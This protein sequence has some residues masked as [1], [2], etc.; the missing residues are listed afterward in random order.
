MLHTTAVLDA[1]LLMTRYLR[2]LLLS[3]AE[4]RLY[5]PRW[6]PDLM[7]EMQRAVQRRAGE[8]WDSVRAQRIARTIELVNRAFPDACVEGYADLIET[9]QLPDPDDRHVLAAALTGNAD[10]IVTFNLKDFPAAALA[11]HGV[12]AI[13]PDAFISRLVDAAPSEVLAAIK[14]MTMRWQR[15]AVHV[16]QALERYRARWGPLPESMTRL[17]DYIDHSQEE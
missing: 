17:L 9:L 11:P 3:L 14:T 12:E 13:P 15:P 4:R 5:R 1:N 16:A 2:D 7:I 10:V 8:A 6:S